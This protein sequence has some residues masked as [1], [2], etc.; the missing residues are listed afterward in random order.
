[1]YRMLHLDVFLLSNSTSNTCH[2]A[3]WAWLKHEPSSKS[4]YKTALVQCFSRFSMNVTRDEKGQQTCE[5]KLCK[6]SNGVA[7][8]TYRILTNC[9]VV[10]TSTQSMCPLT[11]RHAC[12]SQILAHTIYLR[13]DIISNSIYESKFHVWTCASAYFT[14]WWTSIS[15]RNPSWVDYEIFDTKLRCRALLLLV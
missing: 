15:C 1:M 13:Y 14:G 10:E 12:L 6:G 2:Q 8:E 3:Q 5:G 11:T 9:N 7:C 4:M